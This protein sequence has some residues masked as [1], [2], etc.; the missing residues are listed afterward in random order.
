MEKRRSAADVF[1]EQQTIQ[2][3]DMLAGEEVEEEPQVQQMAESIPTETEAAQ[4]MAPPNIPAPKIKTSYSKSKQRRNMML[5]LQKTSEELQIEKEPIQV[6]VT[7][8]LFWQKVIVPPNAY[9]I[10]TRINRKK[11]ITLGLGLSFK[12]NPNTDSYLVIPAAMQTIGV[13]ANCITKEKQGINVLAYVQWQIADFS[14][15]YKKLD[16]SDR[17]DPLGIVNAQL[18]EQTEAAIKDKIATMSVEEVLTDKEP[19]I[20]ELTSRLKQVTEGR[21]QDQDESNK[22]LGIKIVTVQIREAY[23]SS[24]ALWSDLQSPFRHEKRKA[25][26]ISFL[27]MQREIDKKEMETKKLTETNQTETYFE[28]ESLKQKKQTE[29]MQV[30]LKEE[31]IRFSKQQ[32]NLQEKIKQEEKTDLTKKES[33]ERIKVH[34]NKIKQETEIQMLKQENLKHQEQIKLELDATKRKI[35]LEVEKQVISAE[36]NARLIKIKN[37]IEANLIKMRMDIKK[38]Q[39][40]LDIFLQNQ[41][42]EL[43]KIILKSKLDREMTQHK[44]ELTIEKE[45]MQVQLEKDKQSVAIEELY[46]KVRNLMN[47]NDILNRFIAKLP[48]IA[49]KMPEVKELKIFKT[50]NQEDIADSLA[51]FLTKILAVANSLGLKLPAQKSKEDST[52]K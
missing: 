41:R 49:E 22:G 35:A 18:R 40:Q 21:Q 10:H 37:D 47:D 34:E 8:K 24:E 17:N 46:Q 51:T 9:V 45:K 27:N 38:L 26:K 25:A 33:E 2:M 16:F 32:Q 48:E 7:G 39:T 4:K 3:D 42:D 28:I 31:A 14:I 19:I 23:V 6:R 44:T 52:K 5:N 13:V 12:Y 30:K 36:E 1:R 43:E 11:P 20:E 15:A 29:A 50:G